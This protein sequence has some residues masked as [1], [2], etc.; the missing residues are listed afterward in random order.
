M[1]FSF[2]VLKLAQVRVTIEIMASTT[3]PISGITPTLDEKHSGVPARLKDQAK[4]AKELLF[5]RRTTSD[6]AQRTRR[7]QLP[8]DTTQEK[9]DDAITQLKSIVGDPHV[10][11][12][13]Q[14]LVDGWYMEHP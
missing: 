1:G 13:D 4:R 14:A 11:V 5:S 7:I 6:T 2:S 10:Q 12:N 8:P 9:F 3:T